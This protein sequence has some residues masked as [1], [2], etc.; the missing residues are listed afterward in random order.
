MKKENIFRALALVTIFTAVLPFSGC[1][2]KESKEL[3]QKRLQA[4]ARASALVRELRELNEL[5]YK[6]ERKYRKDIEERKNEKKK[7]LENE[8]LEAKRKLDLYRRENN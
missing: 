1:E 6:I 5:G 3:Q 8:Y 7:I 2:D 4:E